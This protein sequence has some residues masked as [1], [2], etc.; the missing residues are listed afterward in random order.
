VAHRR[1]GLHRDMARLVGI[2]GEEL[3][4]WQRRELE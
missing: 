2:D 1:G 3:E 4:E